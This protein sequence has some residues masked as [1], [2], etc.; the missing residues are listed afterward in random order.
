MQ[1]ER[2]SKSP[3]GLKVTQMSLS[4]V[5]TG[6]WRF[7]GAFPAWIVTQGGCF[8]CPQAHTQIVT[9]RQAAHTGLLQEVAVQP[10][11]FCL[12]KLCPRTWAKHLKNVELRCIS[13]DL[14][15]FVSFGLPQKPLQRAVQGVAVEGAGTAHPTPRC[16]SLTR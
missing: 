5:G 3:P 10:N 14:E 9:H 4:Q 1:G 11:P 2:G 15:G 6:V 8:P 13:S 16:S 7:V 12:H